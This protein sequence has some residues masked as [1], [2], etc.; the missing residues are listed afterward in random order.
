[1]NVSRIQSTSSKANREIIHITVLSCSL[2]L[3]HAEAL[4][5]SKKLLSIGVSAVRA[6]SSLA[7]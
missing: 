3:Q 6:G 7:S 1:M 4:L 2:Q 5:P